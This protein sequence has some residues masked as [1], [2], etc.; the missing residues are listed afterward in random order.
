[1]FLKQA[2]LVTTWLFSLNA[3]SQN[4][5]KN[6]KKVDSIVSLLKTQPNDS[7]KVANIHFLFDYFVYKDAEKGKYYADEEIRISK[8]INNETGLANG[9]YNYGVYYNT[10]DKED[11]ARIYY[12]KAYNLFDKL[13]N[14]N[15]K[16]SASYGLAILEYDYG[17]HDEALEITKKNIDLY[18][19]KINDSI[20]LAIDY[21]FIALIYAAKGNFKLAIANS[22]KAVRILEKSNK[23]IRLADALSHLADHE[24]SLEDFTKSLEHK[25][26]AL[27]IYRENDDKYYVTVALNDIGN[28]YYYL[29][30]YDNALEYLKKGLDTANALNLVDIKRNLLDNL[31]KTYTATKDYQKALENLNQAL[32]IAEETKQNYRK[33]EILNNLGTLYN[34]TNKPL[35]ALSTFN[36]AIDLGKKFKNSEALGNSF[37]NRSDTYLNL[38]QPQLA[39]TD[40]KQYTTIKDSIFSKEKTQQI[41]ELRTIYETEKKEQQ[42][43]IQKNEIELLGAKNK[44]SNLQRILLALALA[45]ALIAVYAFYQRNKRNKL[46]KEKAESDLEFKTKELTTHALHLAKKNEVLNDLKQKAKILKADA[47]A[48]PGYQ[49]LIQTI[50]FDLQDDNNWENFSKY[51]EQVHKGFNNKAQKLYPNVT[52]ND[53]RL[54]A[55]L[56]MN[57]SS[58]EIANILN[59]SND[60]IKKARQ[61]LRK[62]MGLDS[63]ESLE[64]VVI[65]I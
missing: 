39:L 54:M 58:K 22:L 13:N 46:A 60:G 49:M 64:V 33:S 36:E 15:G 51:F 3:S 23:P 4:F 31:G 12:K 34:E 62:K 8:L 44:V 37:Y 47:N 25:K 19:N 2:L 24:L 35:K 29:K 65:A 10:I 1:M 48:D 27:S 16:H 5:A 53:L 56:K 40:Y 14:D 45:L 59:I 17:N 52:K 61:R 55:L 9:Y 42:I 30:D 20:R 50:N 63:N 28:T 21:D 41:E 43:Q 11:S 57:L 7:V 26:K 32:K 6:P 18:E 38:K